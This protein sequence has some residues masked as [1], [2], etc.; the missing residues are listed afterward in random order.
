M[1]EFEQLMVF[2][3]G[4]KEFE[5]NMESVQESSFEEIKAKLKLLIQ[6]STYI[7]PACHGQEMYE[8]SIMAKRVFQEVKSTLAEWLSSKDKVKYQIA[9]GVSL[10]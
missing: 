1:T 9:R 3:E 2:T 5:K 4:L 7:S 8:V 6:M 10:Y